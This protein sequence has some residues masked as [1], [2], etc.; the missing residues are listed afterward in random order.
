MTDRRSETTNG[1][2]EDRRPDAARRARRGRRGPFDLNDQQKL[3]LARGPGRPPDPR[4]VHPARPPPPPRLGRAG[5]QAVVARLGDD[6]HDGVAGLL[7]RRA[8]AG[9]HGVIADGADPSAVGLADPHRL[10]EL[11]Q[12]GAVALDGQVVRTRAVPQRQVEIVGRPADRAGGAG[13]RRCPC[14]PW[15]SPRRRPCATATR[16]R[17]RCSAPPGW[18]AGRRGAWSC[19]GGRTTPRARRCRR[20]RTPGRTRVTG[21]PAASCAS[22]RCTAVSWA[23]RRAHMARGDGA[24]RNV[25]HCRSS[26]AAA[27]AAT[28]SVHPCPSQPARSSSAGHVPT[29]LVESRPG[30]SVRPPATKP[31]AQRCTP[32]V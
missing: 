17:R 31:V 14:W 9:A 2:V 4:P 10:G 22:T 29:D 24:A 16:H 25:Q 26:G 3:I 27:S 28:R 30:G 8:P 21:M 6:E 15:W 32:P 7:A 5:A 1:V 18:P 19:G 23:C 13:G 20:R 11:A 12:H